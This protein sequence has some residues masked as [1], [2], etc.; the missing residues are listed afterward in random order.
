M[1]ALGQKLGFAVKRDLE[2]SEY[3]LEINLK[4]LDQAGR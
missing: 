2:F 4:D 3:K 1:L